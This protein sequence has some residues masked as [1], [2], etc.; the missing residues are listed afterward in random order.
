MEKLLKKNFSR[1]IGFWQHV[2]HIHLRRT[3]S[4]AQVLGKE[5]PEKRARATTP[6]EILNVVAM[7]MNK[8]VALIREA[9]A[10]FVSSDVWVQWVQAALNLLS[11]P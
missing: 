3:L 11:N 8:C 5:A 1:T 2:L 9:N 6:L 7:A 10:V 4:Q